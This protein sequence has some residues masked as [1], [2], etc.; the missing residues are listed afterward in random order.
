MGLGGYTVWIEPVF[1]KS[2][3]QTDSN[4]SRELGTSNQNRTVSLCGLNQNRTV[5]T[6]PGRKILTST[7]N[8]KAEHSKTK[9]I[10]ITP[11]YHTIQILKWHTNTTYHPS[12]I[13]TIQMIN[14]LNTNMASHPS[15]HDHHI[16]NTNI[17][18]LGKNKI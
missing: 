9:N 17:A 12:N 3:N 16:Q 5:K 10:Y 13:T 6:E 15:K 11:K 8:L 4:G 18:S 1:Y 14:H 2:I 7:P